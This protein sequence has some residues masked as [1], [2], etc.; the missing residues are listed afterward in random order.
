[1]SLLTVGSALAAPLLR[2]IM[3]V[4]ANKASDGVKEA[5][6]HAAKNLGAAD[7]LI[8][9]TKTTR[10]EPIALVDQR[11]MGRE[12]T[13]QVLNAM[14]ALFTAYYMQA[15][16]LLVSVKRINTLRL[17]DQVNP[18][19]DVSS[20]AGAYLSD[21]VQNVSKESYQFGLPSGKS[22]R[23]SFESAPTTQ[24]Q[25]QN[26]K[27]ADEIKPVKSSAMVSAAKDS[28]SVLNETANLSVGRM[29]DI[30]IEDG[31]GKAKFPVMIR[32][33]VT[34]MA[35]TILAHILGDGSRNTGAVERFHDW[36][37]K[38]GGFKAFV[39]DI[40]LAQDLISAHRQTLM[41]DESGTYAEILNRRSANAKTAMINGTPS[42]NNAA[43][44]VVIS[45]QTAKELERA[46]GARLSD[47]AG[48]QRVFQSSYV[49][50]MAVVDTEWDRVT[51]YHRDIKLPTQLSIKELK[52]SNKG[53]GPDVGEILKAYQLG[54]NPTL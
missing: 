33:I 18:H 9:F 16:A 51:F 14:S 45:S 54:N 23:A 42:I 24:I 39:T 20:A 6:G 8:A 31:S 49:M 5:A 11:L 38:G 47:F 44:L 2:T 15:V 22:I 26:Q 52:V 34:I 50:I 46:I 10:V 40:M 29:V 7:N 41:K 19:R 43:N 4:F 1:M 3:N 21:Y 13:T 48:R 35:P 36:R 37:A 53:T 25:A 28:N 17:L 30:E 32:L 27:A 12:S